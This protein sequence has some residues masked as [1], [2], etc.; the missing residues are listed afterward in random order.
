MQRQTF[1]REVRELLEAED[2]LFGGSLWVRWNRAEIDLDPHRV[3]TPDFGIGRPHAA[4]YASVVRVGVRGE[5]RSGV[6]GFRRDAPVLG[7]N[8]CNRRGDRDFFLRWF[9]ER[10]ANR[11]SDP[12]DQQGADSDRTLDAAVLAV[13]RLGDAHVKRIARL[14]RRALCE[15]GCQ[16]PVRLDGDLRVA[17]LHAED[18]VA[19][20]LA[21]A[22]IEKFERA[23][24]HPSRRVSKAIHDPIG[25]GS[26]IRTDPYRATEFLAASHERA[27][28][29][30]D[31]LDFFRV[32]GVRVLEHCKFLLVCKITGIDP[33]LYRR[34]SAAIIAAFGVK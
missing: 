3:N 19:K 18:D 22:D 21:L 31:A 25:K 17:R 11:I 26:V 27:K 12:V 13:A 2:E 14:A 9:G 15:P 23:L 10:N 7:A 8:R 30:C 24:H 29:L 6:A 4:G 33:D 34:T 5:G 20:S 28:L 32:G 1:T 16:E